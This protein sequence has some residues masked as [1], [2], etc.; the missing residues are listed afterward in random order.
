MT[1]TATD[2]PRRTKEMTKHSPLPPATIEPR[3][4]DMQPTEDG[5]LTTETTSV[6]ETEVSILENPTVTKLPVG[7]VAV[8]TN[9]QGVVMASVSD[10]TRGGYG[11]FTLPQSQKIRVQSLLAVAVAKAY[12]GEPIMEA[13]R[14]ADCTRVVQLL[15]RKGGRV[16]IISVGHPDASTTGANVTTEAEQAGLTA[17]PE[18]AVRPPVGMMGLYADAS[19]RVV[20]TSSEFDQTRYG[21]CTLEESQ[22]R[23]I[24][25]ALARAVVESY[26]SDAVMPALEQMDCVAIVQRLVQKGARVSIIPLGH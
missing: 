17:A 5:S 8:Y 14:T 23:R 6:A 12:C 7:M 24:Q 11:G 3:Q 4:D 2:W 1:I 26:C 21:G 22:E 18:E 10:F 13:L 9:P 19:G 15:C 16:T 25:V 20:V